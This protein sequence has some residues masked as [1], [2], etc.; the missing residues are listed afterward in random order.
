MGD[1]PE[2]GFALR[3]AWIAFAPESR[4]PG[5]RPPNSTIA[6]SKSPSEVISSSAWRPSEASSTS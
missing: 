4:D 2:P 3:S 6:T 1:D 5:T